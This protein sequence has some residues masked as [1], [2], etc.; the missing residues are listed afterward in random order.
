MT[1]RENV[2][3]A[4]HGQKPEW[5][6]SFFSSCQ[7]I[8]AGTSLETPQIG[9]GP[10]YDGYGVHQTPTEGA[11]GMFTPTTSIQPVLKDI[12]KWREQVHFPDY[13]HVPIEQI[14]Q[15]ERQLLHL[16]KS[17]F[18]QDLYCP[19]GIF[20]RIHFLMG[21]EETMYAIMEEPDAVYDLAGAIADKKIEFIKLA[22]RYYQP[23]YF[24]YLDDYAH[25]NGLF[26]SLDTFRELFKPHIKRIVKACHE[27]DMTFK[28]HCCGKMECFLDD[29]LEIGITAF[30]P[31]Q[32]VNDIPAMKKKTLGTAGLMGGLD[33]QHVIDLGGVTEE[34]IRAEVR[35]CIDTYAIDGGYVLYCA[36]VQM[37]NP[38]SYAPTGVIGIINDECAKY[39]AEF[40]KK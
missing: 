10:G 26:M 20:E 32:C 22:G 1:N 29:F 13:S 38:V 23:D 31:V 36:S 15:M 7:I 30:D 19:N 4:L 35:R 25:V 39:G 6:P 33:V 28:M 16:D 18:V 27:T 34:Q 11:G 3:L 8:P 24:T 12:K 2:L 37:F 5:V 21:F 9:L 40:Y 14:A 17:T